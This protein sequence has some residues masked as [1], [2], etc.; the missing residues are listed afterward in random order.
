MSVILAF[1]DS[2]TWGFD[3][4]SATR[5]PREKRWTGVMQRELGD[6]HFVIEEGLNGRTTV[7]DDPEEAGRRGV[8]YLPPCLRSHSPL[9]LVILAL[10]VNDVKARFAASAEEIADG[11]DR[12]AE[13]ASTTPV[14]PRFGPPAVLVVAPPPLARLSGMAEAFA[15]GAEKARAL[16]ALYRRIAERRGLGFVDA[17][18]F[19]RASDLD[20]IHYEADQHALLGHVLAEAAR[21]TLA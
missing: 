21:M 4:A 13:I 15:G 16:P 20:G 11:V 14:G 9:D 1:G 12:L 2:N 7:F 5:L 10:G 6:Q 8:D 19:I 17:G 3:P 18:E